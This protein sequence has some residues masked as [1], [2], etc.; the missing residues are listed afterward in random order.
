MGSLCRWDRELGQCEMKKEYYQE[1]WTIAVTSDQ[2][3]VYTGRDNEIIAA[4]ISEKVK[5]DCSFGGL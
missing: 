3:T 5:N 2:A 4:D 1:I